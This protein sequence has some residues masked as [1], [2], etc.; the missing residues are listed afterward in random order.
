MPQT[1]K[2]YLYYCEKNIEELRP[3]VKFNKQNSINE[4]V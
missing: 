1:R 4:A 2:L 3:E